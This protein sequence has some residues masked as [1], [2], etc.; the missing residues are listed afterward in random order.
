MKRSRRWRNWPLRKSSRPIRNSRSTWRENWDCRSR[1][2]GVTSEGRTGSGIGHFKCEIGDDMLNTLEHEP[3]PR[4]LAALA[5]DPGDAPARVRVP[6][7]VTGTW[8]RGSSK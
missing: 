1:R 6:L 5:G 4:F 8:V 7:A 2:E 3:T